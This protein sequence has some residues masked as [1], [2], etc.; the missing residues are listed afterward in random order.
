MIYKS[1]RKQKHIY[2]GSNSMDELEVNYFNNFITKLILKRNPSGWWKARVKNFGWLKRNGEKSFKAIDGL[3][4]I[5]ATLP[6]CE[7]SFRIYLY[8]KTGL[9]INNAHHDSP[10]WSEWYYITKAKEPIL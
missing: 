5:K 9:A 2:E 4:L 3:E 8:K 6:Q 7:C 10:T 1:K